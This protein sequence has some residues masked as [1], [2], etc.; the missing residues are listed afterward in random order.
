MSLVEVRTLFGKVSGRGD[1]VHP[2]DGSNTGADQFINAGIRLLDQLFDAP[3]QEATHIVKPVSGTEKVSLEYCRSITS[4]QASSVTSNAAYTLDRKSLDY[5]R[6]TYKGYYAYAYGEFTFS[7]NPTAGDTITID[8]TTLEYDVDIVIGSTLANTIDNTVAAINSGV[9]GVT[10]YEQVVGSVVRVAY[11][12]IGVGGNSIAL[13]ES[14]TAITV[15]GSTMSGGLAG[16]DTG[17]PK[18]W[19][20]IETSPS[21]SQ[22]S[23]W[24]GNF[25]GLPFASHLTLTNPYKYVTIWVG[26]PSDGTYALSITG[27]FWRADLSDDSDENWWTYNDPLT[28]A[29]AAT[30]L[31]EAS[32]RNTTGM[33]DAYKYVEMRIMQYDKDQVEAES[34]H[35]SRMRGY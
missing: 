4:V 16:T 11:N 32:Y 27:R 19:C 34:S 24:F 8:T 22:A 17:A 9:T 6:K 10:A 31:L 3:G 18:V 25:A 28:V 23:Q 33:M 1:L 15:S 13:A 12:T 35:Y 29:N 7:S 26:P 2:V 20:P 30:L 14:S 21:T 5:M